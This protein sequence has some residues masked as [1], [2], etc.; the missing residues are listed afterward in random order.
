METKNKMLTNEEKQFIKTIQETFSPNTVEAI[1][2][3]LRKRTEYKNLGATKTQIDWFEMIL[4]EA[5]RGEYV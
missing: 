2:I 3:T 1:F 4:S 5:L